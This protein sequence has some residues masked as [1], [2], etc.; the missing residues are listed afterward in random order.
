MTQRKSPRRGLALGVLLSSTLLALLAAEIGLRLFY[1]TPY[2][3]FEINSPLPHFFRH[4]PLLGWMGVPDASGNFVGRDFS[5]QVNQDPLGYRNLV[6]AFVPGKQ[7]I[8]VLGDS[9]GWGWGV[10]DDEVFS[11]RIM[12]RDDR[13]NVY[14]LSA[15]GYGT[16]QEYLSIQRFLAGAQGADYEGVLLLFYHNDIEDVLS[17]DRYQYPK[18]R[19]VVRD[20]KL[21]LLNVPVPNREKAARGWSDESTHE[22]KKARRGILNDSHLYNLMFVKRFASIRQPRSQKLSTGQRR[23]GRALSLRLLKEI[24]AL[25]RSEQMFFHVVVMETT[26]T[27][28]VWR[29]ELK[30][31][32]DSLEVHGIEFSFFRSR[33]F[34]S[35]DLWLDRHFSRY[36]HELLASH[37]LEVLG[38]NGHLADPR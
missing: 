27:G 10:A 19:F 25:C 18:P 9:Y 35:A 17:A 23:A 26:N 16:D 15:P 6:P 29:D 4:D 7:N 5:L 32:A 2:A 30:G 12:G 13:L 38:Q 1:P 24:G 36:G 37:V 3:G 8:L 28:K 20:S 22:S 11:A 33:V 21:I 34:P 31:L 14:N